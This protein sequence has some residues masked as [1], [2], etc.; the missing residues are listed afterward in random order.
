VIENIEKIFGVVFQPI[1]F[2]GRDEDVE[3]ERRYEQRYTLSQLAD[4]LSDQTGGDLQPL[5]DWF[6]MSVFHDFAKL[7]DILAGPNSQIGAV[8][9]NHYPNSAV[10]SPLVVNTRTKYWAPLARFFNVE[11]FLADLASICEAGRGRSWTQ[12]QL[13][14]AVLRNFHPDQAP[15]GF[16]PTALPDLLQQCFARVSSATP[17]WRERELE[18]GQ[19]RLLLIKGMWFQ[20]LFNFDLRNIEMSTTPVATQEG[21]ISF[22]AYNAGGWRHIVEF[23]HQT[24]PLSEWHRKHGRH[25][26][27]AN[28][29]LIQLKPA[30]API[31][32]AEPTEPCLQSD[33]RRDR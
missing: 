12:S 3:D 23:Q 9:T 15:V 29:Q 28:G 18:S 19:W 11:R 26:I 27:Y 22:C 25:P 24:A 8:A 16:G 5:R 4:D 30:V 1:M 7:V 10:M 17:K 13:Q 33:G 32:M 6:P 20:D 2:A 14:L 31:P 21:E